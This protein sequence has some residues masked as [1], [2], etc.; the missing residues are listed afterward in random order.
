M[1]PAV[2]KLRLCE[3]LPALTGAHTCAGGKSK[4]VDQH[5]GSSSEGITAVE[6]I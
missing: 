2:E 6:R 3:L 1:R 5:D 4:K